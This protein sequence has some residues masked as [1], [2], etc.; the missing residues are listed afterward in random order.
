MGIRIPNLPYRARVQERTTT[1][2]GSG[3]NVTTWRDTALLW[4]NIS[5]TGGREFQAAQ[6]LNAEITHFIVTRYHPSLSPRNR[7]VCSGK[8]YNV[9]QV[10]DPDGRREQLHIMATVTE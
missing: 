10:M 3:G 5:S 8:S 9:V 7:F 6:R 4:C 2:D 1:D